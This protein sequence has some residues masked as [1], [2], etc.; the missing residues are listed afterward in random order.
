[1][2]SWL[3]ANESLYEI[4]PQRLAKDLSKDPANARHGQGEEDSFCEMF[5]GHARRTLAN[6]CRTLQ[7]ARSLG[8]RACRKAQ[9]GTSRNCWKGDLMKIVNRQSEIV[10]AG[11]LPDMDLNHDKQI[12]SLL[13]YRYT[14]GQRRAFKLKN[15]V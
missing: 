7:D 5:G 3:A 13:C 2:K 8:Q 4:E 6:E 14:I 15:F 1:M 10:N 11:W 9:A 12:Q